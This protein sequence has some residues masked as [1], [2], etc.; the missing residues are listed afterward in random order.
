MSTQGIKLEE[1]IQKRLKALA[2]IR[3]RSPH[4]LMRTAIQTYLEKEENY[5]R[6]KREDMAR[7]E[8]YQLTGAAIPHDKVAE[9]LRDLAEGK[10]PSWPT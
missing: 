10:T 7:W 8:N 9:W 4:W 1:D 2:K 3:D 5:E 6:E